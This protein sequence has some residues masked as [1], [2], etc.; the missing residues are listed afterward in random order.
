MTSYIR[1][2]VGDR[3]RFPTPRMVD[4]QLGVHT[5]TSCTAGPRCNNFGT[6]YGTSGY[7]SPIVI[8][9]WASSFRIPS[10]HA[11][12]QS[13]ARAPITADDTT[14]HPIAR[15]TPSLSAEYAG[16]HVHSHFRQIHI[17][18]SIPAVAV[19]PVSQESA[20]SFH[21]LIPCALCCKACKYLVTSMIT[22]FIE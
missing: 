14:S 7:L 1:F 20:G 11:R 2:D 8:R 15:R 19:M 9:P 16:D 17:R 12:N 18:T 5:R 10:S 6:A 13:T 4:K 3:A 22:S 21:G